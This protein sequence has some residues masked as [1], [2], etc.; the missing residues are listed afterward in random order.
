MTKEKM[1]KQVK[2]EVYMF[3]NRLNDF[4]EK[5]KATGDTYVAIIPVDKQYMGSDTK[6]MEQYIKS[7]LT[8]KDEPLF[9]DTK[10]VRVRTPS[11]GN[12]AYFPDNFDHLY[13]LAS[14]N[15][16][17]PV[18]KSTNM[19]AWDKYE[20]C[21]TQIED[22]ESAYVGSK[23]GTMNLEPIGITFKHIYLVSTLSNTK[24]NKIVETLLKDLPDRPI[25]EN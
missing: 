19:P 20:D 16:R 14:S 13:I 22:Q 23:L 21:F 4:V 2:H 25:V 15:K 5:R 11:G 12:P 9:T 17:R 18:L 8:N 3:N 6:L 1:E 7:I 24:L 10:T